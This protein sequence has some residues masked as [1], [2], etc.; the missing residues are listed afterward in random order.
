[1]EVTVKQISSPWILVELKDTIGARHIEYALNE[2][3]EMHQIGNFTPYS[4]KPSSEL[5]DEL[6]NNMG[7]YEPLLEAAACEISI[8]V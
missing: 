2:S 6:V 3:G 8:K 1:M 4:E 7:F 5:G